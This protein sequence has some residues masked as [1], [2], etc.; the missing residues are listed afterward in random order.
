MPSLRSLFG[1]GSHS[2]AQLASEPP[3]EPVPAA[4]AQSVNRLVS[5][6][7]QDEIEL[8]MEITAWS[9]RRLQT[10]FTTLDQSPNQQAVQDAQAARNCFTR[11]WLSA[12]V[13][14][15]EILYSG[16]IGEAYRLMLRGILPAL[17]LRPIDERWK[18][19]LSQ[20]LLKAFGHHETPNL[21]LAVMPYYDR[22]AMKVADPARQIPEW[23][24]SDYAERCDPQL[25]QKLRLRQQGGNGATAGSPAMLAPA[26]A[27]TDTRPLPLFSEKRGED[28][29]PLIQDNE[30]LGRMSGLINL[31]AIDPS[32]AE[33]KRELAVLRRQVAQIWLDVDPG[34]LETLYRAPFGQLSQNLI[35]SGFSREAMPPEEDAARRR[36]GEIVA[37]MRHPRALNALMAALLYY[38]ASK[39]N[40]SSAEKVL[41]EWLLQELTTLRSRASQQ[42]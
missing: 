21:L 29:L 34:Q 36:L 40:L 37:T 10:I 39:V 32:D 7:P 27:Q 30:F 8:P 35:G 18:A 11:F 31:Y 23:L 13:D 2:H 16:P 5:T 20:R 28:C 41:P 38:P 22:N 1:R 25:L 42:G 33:L 17:P 26:P 6:S 3:I 14:C 12:P 19:G 24:L 4:V 15:L 9:V